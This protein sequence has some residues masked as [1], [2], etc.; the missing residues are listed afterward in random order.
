LRGYT[1]KAV[2]STVLEVVIRPPIVTMEKDVEATGGIEELMWDLVER[3]FV[4]VESDGSKANEVGEEELKSDEEAAPGVTVQNEANYASSTNDD[5]ITQPSKSLNKKLG[6][7]FENVGGLDAQ[8]DDIARRVLASRANP[9]AA[10]RLGVSHV[11]GILL[12]GPPG[13]GKTLLARELSR[14][15]GAR[16][17]QIVNGPEI[18]DKF[19]G[20]AERRVRDLFAPAER[21][22]DEVGDAS[23]LHLIILDEIDAIARKRGSMTSDTTGVRDS[24]VN[25][26]LAKIDGVK[27][28]SNILVVG[29][30]NRPELIDPALLRPGRLEVQLRVE[31]PGEIHLKHQE[32]PYMF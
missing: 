3:V 28:A 27:E 11:R 10:R 32:S 25:Q 19:I 22:Y 31:L 15:L 30:T 7:D 9:E 14:L 5:I 16:E 20:E 13:C 6:M 1:G 18:L 4:Q 17:P 26:L 12:S 21:E 8:L 23:A 24:V 29:L 2:V